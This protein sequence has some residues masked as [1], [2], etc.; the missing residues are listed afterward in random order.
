MLNKAFIDLNN[1]RHNALAIKSMLNKDVKFCAVV[2][3][4]GYGHGAGECANAIYDIVDYFAVAIVEEG[5]SLRYAGIQKDILVL[6]PPFK[7]DIERAI[8]YDLTLSVSDIKLLKRIAQIAKKLNS[9]VKVHVKYNTGMNRLGVDSLD[10]LNKILE[11]ID[12]SNEIILDGFYSHLAKPEDK[13]QLKLAITKFLL[14]LKSVKRYNNKVLAHISA[15]GGLLKGYQFDMVR[16]GIMLY[17]YTPFKSDCIKLK[18]VMR[19]YAPV[20]TRRRIKKGE[21]CLYGN[22][23]SNRDVGITI[24]RCGY[25][26][27]FFREQTKGQYNNRCMDLTAVDKVVKGKYFC[28]MRDADVL[29]KRHRTISYEILV[30]ATNR[31]ERIYIR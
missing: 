3:A 14:A 22:K 30:S 10:E 5:V 20:V 19:V 26:D 17:G 29:A 27:G 4:D 6:V 15:S 24:I 11:F 16:V 21:L 1:L 7:N 25:A 12:K 18:K 2:K 13:K 9:Q 28:V 8:L 23:Q 31:A